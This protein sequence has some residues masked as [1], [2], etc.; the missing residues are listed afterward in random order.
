MR[1]EYIEMRLLIREEYTEMSLLM[2]E[3]YS[4][5]SLLM[6]AE[7]SEM[8]FEQTVGEEGTVGMRRGDCRNEKGGL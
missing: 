7:Y 2:R 1:A 8:G 5:M 3:E 4:E 6:R